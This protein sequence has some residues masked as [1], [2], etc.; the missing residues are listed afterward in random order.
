MSNGGG[1]NNILEVSNLTAGY[2]S[3]IDILTDINLKVEEGKMVAIIGPN[4]AGKSTLLKS[5]FGLLGPK[6]GT[7]QFDGNNI[8][9]NIARI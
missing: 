5:I 1:V 6:S 8:T 3:D 7:V 2:Y 9:G 4:G